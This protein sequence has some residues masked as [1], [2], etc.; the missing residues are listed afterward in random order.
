MYHI[1]DPQDIYD[2]SY[3]ANFAKKNEEPFKMIQGWRVPENKF[4][5]D[6][7]GMYPVASLENHYNYEVV[8][9][10]RLYGLLNNANF[11]IKW[12]PLIDACV[13]SHIMNGATILSDNL[14]TAITEY[15]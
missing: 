12:V 13:N 8:M 3:L 11:S 15:R 6:K 9:L 4:K 5:F 1:P 14:A 2:K 10:C 7:R